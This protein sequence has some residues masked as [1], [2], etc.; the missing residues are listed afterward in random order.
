MFK[1][2]YHQNLPIVRALYVLMVALID[3]FT[4][5]PV[6]INQALMRGDGADRDL[7]CASSSAS[8][9]SDCR[10]RFSGVSACVSVGVLWK[11]S[12]KNKDRKGLLQGFHKGAKSLRV[13]TLKPGLGRASIIVIV[14]AI[15]VL[16]PSLFSSS[17][18]NNNT[19]SCLHPPH[20][21]C[22][23]S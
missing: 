7:V 6:R 2:P 1:A 13:S 14:R 4:R 12:K 9:A 17:Y 23:A 16:N 3:T 15:L 18:H 5:D 10:V 8:Q 21:R 11:S 19:Q 20:H 22:H